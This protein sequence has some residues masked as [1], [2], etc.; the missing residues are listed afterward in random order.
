[1]REVLGFFFFLFVCF[2]LSVPVKVKIL[3]DSEGTTGASLICLNPR[4]YYAN[5]LSVRL[6]VGLIASHGHLFTW[7]KKEKKR[8]ST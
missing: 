5:E 4:H 3:P 1:M 8:S 7:R 2:P 6:A